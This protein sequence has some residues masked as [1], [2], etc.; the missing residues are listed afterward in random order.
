MS[1][2]TELKAIPDID[3]MS[4]HAREVFKAINE[5]KEPYSRAQMHIQFFALYQLS[6]QIELELDDTE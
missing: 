3:D 1:N 5:V 4:E 6:T 2:V